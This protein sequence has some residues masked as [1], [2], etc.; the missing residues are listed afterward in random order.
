MK[1]EL[2]DIPEEGLR[3]QGEESSQILALSD[4]RMLRAFGAEVEA[5]G[6]SVTVRGGAALRS[7]GR[8][9]VPSDI[10]SAAGP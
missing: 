9:D 6:A 8:I 5:E 4:E 3:V 7:P 2:G 1:I 10:S